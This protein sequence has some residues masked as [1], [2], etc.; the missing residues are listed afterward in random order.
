MMAAH[1][2]TNARELQGLFTERVAS[3]LRRDGHEVVAWDEVLEAEVPPGTIIAAWRSSD[4]ALEAARRGFDVVMAPMQYV[5]FDWLSSDDP[6]E[7]VAVHGAPNV[8]TWE[9]VYEF[10]VVPSELEPEL[11]HHVR[12]AQAQLWTEYIATRDALDYMAFPRLA[13]FSEVVWG[14]TT[15]LL[16]C[17]G[18]LEAHLDRLDAM[19]VKYRTLEVTS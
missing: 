8:T 14:T 16:E 18:R 10:P 9:K 15:T 17:R 19:G 6:A 11:R 13:V 2:F 7:P 1:G 5:Y 3:A 12:G 4:K